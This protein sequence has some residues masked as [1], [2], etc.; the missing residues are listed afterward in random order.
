MNIIIGFIFLIVGVFFLW[1]VIK[2]PRKNKRDPLTT[3]L[4]I[5]LGSILLIIIGILSLCGI[6]KW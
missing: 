5:Y 2:H 4:R 3:N 6:M 1:N